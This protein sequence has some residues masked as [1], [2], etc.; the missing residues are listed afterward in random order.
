MGEEPSKRTPEERKRLLEA[1]ILRHVE[2]GW[3]VESQGEFH[4]SLVKGDPIN[5]VLHF[6][7]SFFTCGLWLIVWL[8]MGL[9]G[10]QE[11]KT[12]TVGEYGPRDKTASRENVE[13][14]RAARRSGGRGT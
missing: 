2:R 11:R 14:F 1:S 7:I 10:G 12:I 3:R 13:N 5:H 8:V 4:A 6:L 9:T